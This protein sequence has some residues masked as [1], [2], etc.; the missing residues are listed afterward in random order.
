MRVKII[1]LSLI[2]VFGLLVSGCVFPQK[3]KAKPVKSTQKPIVIKVQKKVDPVDRAIS[4]KKKELSF[5]NSNPIKEFSV[6]GEGIAP[7]N[8]ISPA[9]ALVLAKRA[10]VADAYRQLGEKLYGVRV[11]ARETVKDAA[12]KDSKIIT[13][14]NGLIKDAYITES[15]YK[16]GLYRVKMELKI[17]SKTWKRI[18]SY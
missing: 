1:S 3:P 18:F 11:N 13:Q 15:S 2:V 17:D 14:V 6:V 10:A 12:L 8:T 5:L 9:Q 16:N 7:K 4:V